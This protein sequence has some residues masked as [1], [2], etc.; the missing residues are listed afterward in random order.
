MPSYMLTE[1]TL[2]MSVF[3]GVR[4]SP[5]DSRALSHRHRNPVP[6]RPLAVPTSDLLWPGL[7]RR[8]WIC[9]PWTG[10]VCVLLRGSF[11]P[12]PVVFRG[13]VERFVSS[14]PCVCAGGLDVTPQAPRVPSAVHRRRHLLG[15]V[16]LLVLRVWGL[17]VL[18]VT[19]VS[20]P[21]SRR[22][23]VCPLPS[24]GVSG[25][26]SGVGDGAQV[27]RSGVAQAGVA[28]SLQEA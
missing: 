17:H 12:S 19:H 7:V 15:S 27:P 2:A 26:P 13:P 6:Q 20:S 25:L 10:P 1:C 14:G 16:L 28:V 22:T 11:P 3:D 21:S 5:P 4:P 18:C 8:L 9:L 23:P 24:R